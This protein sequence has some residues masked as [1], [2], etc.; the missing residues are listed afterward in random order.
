MSGGVP[1]RLE[2]MVADILSR[3]MEL[4]IDDQIEVLAVTLAAWC[5]ARDR[6]GTGRR[7]ALTDAGF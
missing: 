1:E 7:D 4:P 5:Y 3:I 6:L 2:P